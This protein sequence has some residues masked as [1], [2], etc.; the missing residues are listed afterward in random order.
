MAQ[1]TVRGVDD[2]VVRKL[3]VRAA[4][5]GCSAEAEHR[6]ILKQALSGSGE[7]S[8]QLR[9]MQEERVTWSEQRNATPSS[10]LTIEADEAL[11]HRLKIQAALN[12]RSIEAEAQAILKETAEAREREWWRETREF[13]EELREKY[14]TFPDSSEEFSDMRAERIRYLEERDAPPKPPRR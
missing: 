7:E 14:G 6:D 11:V 5:K 12:H 13:C 3:K 10:Q 1:L 8:S 4:E 2:E 9:Q